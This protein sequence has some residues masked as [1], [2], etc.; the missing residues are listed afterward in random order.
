MVYT[1][2]SSETTSGWFLEVRSC[3]LLVCSGIHCIVWAA[4]LFLGHPY[5]ESATTKIHTVQ[6]LLY[7]HKNIMVWELLSPVPVCLL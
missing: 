3:L 7:T 5:I 1:Q 6:P 4:I 2:K